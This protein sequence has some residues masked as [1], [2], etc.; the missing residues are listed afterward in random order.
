MDNP[1]LHQD[2]ARWRLDD[3]G[4]LSSG[5]TWHELEDVDKT[6]DAGTGELDINVRLRFSVSITVADFT[7][8]WQLQ[9]DLNGAGFL[10]VNASSLVA[11]SSASP[12]FADNDDTTEHGVTYVGAAFTVTNSGMNENDGSTPNELITFGNFS[13]VEYCFQLREVDLSNSDTID[14]RLIGGGDTMSTENIIRADI[15]GIAAGGGV[16]IPVAMA[17]YRRRHERVR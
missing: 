7:K 10:D 11:R 1:V 2:H 17:S 14:F 3:G 5:A 6:F 8:G 9:Y 4:E 12:N 15:T 13:S 16:P